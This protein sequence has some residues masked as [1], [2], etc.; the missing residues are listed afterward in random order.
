MQKVII[1]I[2]IVL[3]LLGIGIGLLVFDSFE[4]S[5]QPGQ[6]KEPNNDTSTSTGVDR[7]FYESLKERHPQ[8]VAASS[9][10]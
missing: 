8:G 2:I 6:T 1:T 7:S 10:T 3:V 5:E 4:R 9:Q